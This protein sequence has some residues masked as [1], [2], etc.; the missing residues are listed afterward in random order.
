MNLIEPK[1]QEFTDQKGRTKKFILS[2]FDCVTG[3]EIYSKYPI[4]NLPAIGDYPQSEE[5]MFKLMSFVAI[6]NN[7]TPLRLTIPDLVKNHISDWEMLIAIERAMLAYNFSFFS[8]GKGLTSFAEL[9]KKVTEWTTKIST[10]S[11][12]RFLILAKQHLS[13][14]EQ[15]TR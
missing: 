14:S 10:D 1:E 4:S 15:N 7:G 3:R 2:K 12:A 6:D 5:T 8:D 11:L 9:L 13:S